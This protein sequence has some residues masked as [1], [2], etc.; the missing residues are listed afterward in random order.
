M[1]KLQYE[2]ILIRYGELTTKGKN[3]KDFIRKL[4]E[5]MRMALADFDGL[6][7]ERTRDHI[8]VHLHGNDPDKIEPILQK[9]FGI[10][11]FSKAI[12]TSNDIDKIVECSLTLMKDKCGS[13]KVITKRANKKFPIHSDEVN[14]KVASNI[15]KNYAPDLYVDVHNPQYPLI[16]EIR[17]NNTY[18]M[19]KT[20]L[21]AQGYPVGVAGKAMLMLSGGIDSPVAGYLAMKR[22]IQIECIHYSSQPYTSVAALNKV[23]QLARMLSPYQGSIALHVVPFTETQLAIYKHCDES[24]AI[25]MMRRM[26]YRLAERLAIKQNCLAIVNGES[27]GQVASQTLDSIGVINEVTS[28]PVIRPVVTYDKLEIIDIAKK[29]GTYETSILPFEDC[30]TIFNPKNPTTKPRL[31]KCI[32]YEEKYDFE[33][34]LSKAIEETETIYIYPNTKFEDEEIF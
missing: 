5:N 24:Y 23:K 1:D 30:C 34:L 11:S 27:V 31:D 33:S 13:F 19:C 9:V 12:K 2:Y 25:T 20:V 3:K 29:I 21:G 6:T 7:F 4:A 16:I 32:W 18:L 8:Y 22:G 15:L 28:M 17:E 10:R 26:M 14:R